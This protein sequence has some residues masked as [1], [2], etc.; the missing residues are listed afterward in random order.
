MAS[1]RTVGDERALQKE[2]CI[3]GPEGGKEFGRFKAMKGHSVGGTQ[4][5][6][7]REVEKCQITQQSLTD[8]GKGCGLRLT[9]SRR[10]KRVTSRRVVVQVTLATGRRQD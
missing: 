4:V 10:H 1:Q 8:H 7:S 2:E 5:G 9:S 3:Q 6:M